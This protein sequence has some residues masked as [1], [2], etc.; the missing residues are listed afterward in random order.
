ML[1]APLHITKGIDVGGVLLWVNSVC[2][3]ADN[4]GFICHMDEFALYSEPQFQSV[5]R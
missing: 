4:D 5:H 3:D 1:H 2:W